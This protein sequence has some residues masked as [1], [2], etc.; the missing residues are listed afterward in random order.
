MLSLLL[1]EVKNRR[2]TRGESSRTQGKLLGR[3]R[4]LAGI[5]LD[6]LGVRSVGSFWGG[7]ARRVKA[8]ASQPTGLGNE[9]WPLTA[10]RPA[11]GQSSTTTF[12][13]TTSDPALRTYV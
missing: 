3:G 5:G 9:G 11:P 7:Q 8:G 2:W 1:V 4:V 12:P 13:R 6:Q 10:D